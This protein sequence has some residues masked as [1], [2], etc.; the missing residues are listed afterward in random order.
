MDNTN[1]GVFIGSVSF[2]R[3][4]GLDPLTKTERASRLPDKTS[5]QNRKMCNFL[6]INKTI[7]YHPTK[8]NPK[9]RNIS[10]LSPTQ[11]RSDLRSQFPPMALSSKSN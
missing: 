2:C 6:G 1:I 5:H 3:L 8:I 11:Q 4:T 7:S 10:S 9:S